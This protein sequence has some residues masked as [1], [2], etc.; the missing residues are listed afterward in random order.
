MYSLYND[1]ILDY[2]ELGYAR[3]LADGEA[4]V[5]SDKTWTIPHHPVVNPNKPGQI[6]VVKDAAAIFGRTS[7]NKS[8]ET[9][10]DLL[11]SLIGNILRF[12]MGRVAIAADITAI[13]HQVR[14]P[15]KDSHSLRFLWTNDINSNKEPYVLQMLVDI[16]GAKDSPT[17]ANYAVKRT[18]RDNQHLFDP[19]T[20]ETAL[21]AFYVDNLLK[22]SNSEAVAIT[23]SK[24]L[25]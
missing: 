7:L 22:S 5:V 18:A 8:L 1:Q 17:C 21:K 24:G 9:G 25:I 15:R 20:F 16:F 4:A 19:L 3:R 13:F 2:I 23:L 6:W 14:V 12:R 11:S 10:P